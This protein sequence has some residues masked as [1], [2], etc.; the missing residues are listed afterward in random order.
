[1]TIII[2]ILLNFITGILLNFES[3]T[4]SKIYETYAIIEKKEKTDVCKWTAQYN[5][6]L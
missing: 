5:T 1:M 2:T 4:Y 3:H 6:D